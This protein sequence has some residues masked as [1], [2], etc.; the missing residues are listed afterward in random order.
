MLAPAVVDAEGASVT[1][2]CL[3]AATSARE[4]CAACASRVETR[5]KPSPDVS[6][7]GNSPVDGSSWWC[8]EDEMAETILWTKPRIPPSFSACSVVAVVSCVEVAVAAA[9]CE[10]RELSLRRLDKLKRRG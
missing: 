5:R 2:G 6:P 7:A 9:E 1:S 10:S 4:A 3:P 8:E